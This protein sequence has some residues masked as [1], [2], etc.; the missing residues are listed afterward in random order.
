MTLSQFIERSTLL[1]SQ[2]SP[3]VSPTAV[4]T[5]PPQG[6][7]F[8]VIA[9]LALGFFIGLLLTKALRNRFR[10]FYEKHPSFRHVSHYVDKLIPFA[11]GAITGVF[12]L[13]RRS[14]FSTSDP[15]L[16]TLYGV[17]GC[18]VALGFGTSWLIAI[19]KDD[20]KTRLRRLETETAQAVRQRDVSLQAIAAISAVIKS[21]KKRLVET[22]K[23]TPEVR[24]ASLPEA[25]GPKVQ[26]FTL[27]QSLH[28][29]FARY[30]VNQER[31]RIGIYMR[32]PEDPQTLAALYSWDGTRENCISNGHAGYMNLDGPGGA[33]SL[34]VECYRSSTPLLM[35]A[36]CEQAAAENKFV[37]FDPDQRMKLKSM[38]AYR[39]NLQLSEKPDAL[40]LTMDTDKAG[41]FSSDREFECQ[42][43]LEETG[44]RLDLELTA[45]ELINKLSP[46]P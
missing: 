43:L 4:S 20:D 33:R 3:P 7:Y 32:S 14:S 19:S 18:L 41:F 28:K 21:K 42:L 38:V 17:T 5:Q 24:L 16:V 15:F 23:A 39:Y 10:L 25:L 34:V 6:S 40:I 30:L 37:F 12:E 8:V 29:H 26:V 22:L 13:W 45:L 1:F 2:I 27:I 36:N 35:V 31:L 46:N 44:N 11:I 9:V